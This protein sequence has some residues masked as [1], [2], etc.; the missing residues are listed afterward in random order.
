MLADK[1]SMAGRSN[2]R[3]RRRTQHFGYILS[4]DFSSTAKDHGTIL[5][6]LAAF[7]RSQTNRNLESEY[8]IAITPGR[9][10]DSTAC[11]SCIVGWGVG[12]IRWACWT[13]V[14]SFRWNTFFPCLRYKSLFGYV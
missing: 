12:V 5:G 6:F 4:M 2:P 14:S 10:V 1:N 7:C 3:S 9:I 8:R 13:T 11:A